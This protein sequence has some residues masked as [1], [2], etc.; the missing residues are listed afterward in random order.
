M[1]RTKYQEQKIREESEP[2]SE[3]IMAA[4]AGWSGA[5]PP[6]AMIRR[7]IVVEE[8]KKKSDF[9]SRKLE[10]ESVSIAMKRKQRAKY[11]GRVEYIAIQPEVELMLEQGHSCKAIFEE[12]SRKGRITISYGTF[13]DYVRGGGQR[14]RNSERHIRNRKPT[15]LTPGQSGQPRGGP[16]APREAPPGPFV[17]DKTIDVPK[18]M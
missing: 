11:D 6:A 3:P 2:V 8:M 18:L 4:V 12:M 13:C 5:A 17:F 14:F 9:T 1:S 10:V 7:R 15:G 16:A